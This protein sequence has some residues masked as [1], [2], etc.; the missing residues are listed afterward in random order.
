M[1][2]RKAHPE[3]PGSCHVGFLSADF[4]HKYIEDVQL[5]SPHGLAIKVGMISY[6]IPTDLATS[7]NK[8]ALSAIRRA[9]VYAKAL[10]NTP[11]PV[12]VSMRREDKSAIAYHWLEGMIPL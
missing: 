8:Q 5:T 10:S 6:F 4:P 1:L 11:G 7:L 9:S 3:Q 2:I 12:S